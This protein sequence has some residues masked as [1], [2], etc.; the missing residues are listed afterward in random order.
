MTPD[1]ALEFLRAIERGEITLVAERCPQDVYAGNVGYKASNGWTI[2]VFNDC[3]EWDYPDC[4][5]LP[6]RPSVG[7]WLYTDGTDTITGPDRDEEIDPAWEPVRTYKPRH[8][9]RW[10]A[11]RIPGYL[12]NRCE[13]CG[14]WD[15]KAD[16][17]GTYDVVGNE[18]FCYE[19]R[20]VPR[21]EDS[22]CHDSELEKF[23][24]D[25]TRRL[26][27]IDVQKARQ[28]VIDDEALMKKER[29]PC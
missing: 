6:G 25:E 15:A 18:L 27:D 21:P 19:C 12:N 1:E 11:Y 2:V 14:R 7:F 26:V 16:A 8:A 3:N 5:E 10:S 17:Q 9:V 22:P 13:K 4:I 24:S 20:G 28:A 29:K 23:V